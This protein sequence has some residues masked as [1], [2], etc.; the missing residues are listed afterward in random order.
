[1]KKRF[2]PGGL[3][4]MSKKDYS[5]IEITKGQ[6]NI[7]LEQVEEALE[8]ELQETVNKVVDKMR[9]DLGLSQSL[10]NLIPQ[11]QLDEWKLQYGELYRTVLNDQTFLWHKM[12]RREYIALMT[13]TELSDIKNADVRIFVRQERILKTCVLYPD[14]DTLEKIMDYNAGVASNISDEIMLASGFRIGKTEKVE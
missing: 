2:L 9:E 8:P 11:Q 7:N 6:M 14:Q 4:F 10:T 1:M 13:D 12:R 3:C 5:E